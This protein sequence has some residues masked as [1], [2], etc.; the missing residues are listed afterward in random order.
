MDQHQSTEDT[1]RRD[2]KQMA[3][4]QNPGS[5]VSPNLPVNGCSSPQ[6]LGPKVLTQT[7]ICVPEIQI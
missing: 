7:Q 5:L 6:I 1:N 3:M 4:G 2:E